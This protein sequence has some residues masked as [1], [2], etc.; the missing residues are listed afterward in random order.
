MYAVVHQESG[1]HQ[2]LLAA[3]ARLAKKG[4]TKAKVGAHFCSH[5]RQPCRKCKK[6]FGR[7]CSEVC[8]WMDRQYSSL[9]LDHWLRELQT[10]CVL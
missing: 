7:I 3:K 8:V 4:L 6:H 5:G 2:S 9:A 1:M 10:I